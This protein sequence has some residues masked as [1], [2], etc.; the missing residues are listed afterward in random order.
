M[1]LDP[2]TYDVEFLQ[3]GVL[4]ETGEFTLDGTVSP[5]DHRYILTSED[6]GIAPVSSLSTN[7]SNIQDFIDYAAENNLLAVLGA[8][9]W[10]VN[11][12][13]FLRNGSR[14]KGRGA[15]HSIINAPEGQWNPS[16][17]YLFRQESSDGTNTDGLYLADLR[18]IGA[19]KDR[20][21]NGPLV[22]IEA[23]YNFVIE[24][25]I[26]EDPSSYGIY[27][28]GYD[29]SKNP[30][31]SDD[32]TNPLWQNTHRGTVRD[33]LALRGQIGF[34]TEGNAEN[35]LFQRCTSIGNYGVSESSW[36]LHGYRSASGINVWYDRCRAYGYRNGFLVDRYRNM[37]YSGCYIEKCRNGIAMGSYYPDDPIVSHDMRIIGNYFNCEEENGTGP[38][39][40][41]DFYISNR[42]CDGVVVMG[43]T[44]RGSGGLRFGQSKRLN[45]QGNVSTDGQASIITSHGATGLVANNTMPLSQKA[46]GITDGGNNISL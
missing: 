36:G 45:V 22:R 23:C 32:I 27:I 15:G 9:T 10:N 19:D 18:C 21:D 28:T 46:S 41:N 40:V 39:A 44:I 38:L 4:Q 13:L 25:M 31:Y 34:G 24:R 2:G 17:F 14:L 7:A 37:M 26:V 42:Q 33:C 35:I 12:T 3:N 16:D 8:G 1:S 20:T 5:V 29:Y 6:F 30:G 11:T 43:N